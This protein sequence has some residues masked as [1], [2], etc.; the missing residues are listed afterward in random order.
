MRMS[1]LALLV[2]V[3]LGSA[4]DNELS[5]RRAPGFSLPDADFNRYDLQD[6]HGSKWV[7]IEFINT[8]CPHCRELSKALE[9]IKPRFD[10][11]IQFLAVVL[12]PDNTATVA[13]YAAEL[14][15]TYPLLFDQGQM[16]ASYFNASPANPRFHTPHVFIID[17][18]GTIVRD[19]GHSEENEASTQSA[20]LTKLLDDLLSG[21][22][23]PI[24]MK[25]QSAALIA[26]R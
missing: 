1:V 5:G 24:P 14:H 11:K 2:F 9:E 19:F 15:L 21:K 4:A 25:R 13:K 12:P 16:A 6:Y 7:V 8:N 18:S 10:R 23:A 20:G 3:S 26:P 17:A 22:A